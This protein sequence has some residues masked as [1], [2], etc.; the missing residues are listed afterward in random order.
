MYLCCSLVFITYISPN[1]TMNRLFDELKTI[2]RFDEQQQFT[3]KWLDEEGEE[4][5]R[6][7]F[8]FVMLI[9]ATLCLFSGDPCTVSS[10]IELEEAI[11]L[12]EV[13]KDTEL[14]L[15]S[16]VFGFCFEGNLSSGYF[17]TGNNKRFLLCSLSFRAR[18]TGTTVRWRG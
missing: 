17:S 15:H 7:L 3:V 9:I 10:Q 2:C 13:N 18:T 16:T 14:T 11:R 5:A 4:T 1:T 8:V 6:T 12:Y